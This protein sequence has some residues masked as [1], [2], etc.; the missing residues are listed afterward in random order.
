LYKEVVMMSP[1]ETLRHEHEVILLVLGGIERATV[2][3]GAA[4]RAEPEWLDTIVDFVRNFADRC[5]HAKEEK[6]LFPRMEERGV[7]RNGGPIGVMLQEHERGRAFIR[8][9]ADAT[10]GAKAGDARALATASRN[11]L[12]YVGLLRAHIGKENSVLFPMA[13]QVLTEDDQRELAEAF[14]RVEAEELG[15]GTHERYHQLAHQLGA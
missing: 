15:E 3:L 1:T 14:D 8:A 10:S 12:Y 6:H 5:H 4:L 9:V 11:L 7:P 13:D 2:D